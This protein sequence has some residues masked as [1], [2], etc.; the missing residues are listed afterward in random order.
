KWMYHT[1]SD[2]LGV[3]MARA[4]GRPLPE[5]L[6][7][8]IFG[9]LGMPDTGFHVPAATLHRLAVAYQPDPQTGALVL[10]DDPRQSQSGHPP[11][12][13]S[14]GGGLVSTADDLLAFCAMMLNKGRYAGGRL[15]S[16]PSVEVIA[17]DQL[18]SPQKGVNTLF[19][20]GPTPP[21]LW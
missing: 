8:R 11:A 10:T 12:F 20:S 7:E 16:P 5:L 19:F 13:P 3:L 21:A 14:A 4:T 2:A 17:H 1:G 6:A 18:P 9:P 15:L